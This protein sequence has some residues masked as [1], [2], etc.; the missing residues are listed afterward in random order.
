MYQVETTTP[1]G[2]DKASPKEIKLNIL[3]PTFE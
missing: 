1:K 3:H 2:Y